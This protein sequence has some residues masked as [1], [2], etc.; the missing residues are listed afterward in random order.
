MRLKLW[1]GMGSVAGGFGSARFVKDKTK[2]K[3]GDRGVHLARF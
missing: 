1:D 2:E 3:E